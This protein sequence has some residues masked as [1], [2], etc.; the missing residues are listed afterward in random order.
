MLGLY[1]LQEKLLEA[2]PD[3]LLENC[4]SGGARFDPGMLYY[5]PQIWCSDDMDPMVRTAIHE[6]T[7]LLYPLSCIGSHVCKEKNDITGRETPFETRA[8]SA[9]TGTFGYELN[10]CTLTEEEKRKIPEQ[11]R[12]YRQ[13]EPLLQRGEYYRLSS[14]DQAD[15][16]DVFE[17][18]DP[19]Q[20]TG[21]VM[22][23]Q[24]LS[25][26]NSVSVRIRLRGL[27]EDALYEVRGRGIA[28]NG[29]Q[30]PLGSVNIWGEA[31]GA[32]AGKEESV[33]LHGDTLMRAGY[34]V[35]LPKQDFAAVLHRIRQEE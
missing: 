5:S 14:A 27:K 34:I 31:D 26:A 32:D 12:L 35:C 18:M 13:L 30:K 4:S 10:I 21:Y 11:I 19:E 16:L 7:A 25:A 15:R 20:R 24:V 6:G 2:F 1:R 9:M 8:L 29:D 23:T 33:L 3:L 22:I 28:G 17:V